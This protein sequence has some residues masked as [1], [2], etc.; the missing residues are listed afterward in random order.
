MSR[1]LILSL[2]LVLVGSAM[3]AI[4]AEP[5]A[6]Q[7]AVI[8]AL[9]GSEWR[10]SNLPGRNLAQV[11]VQR[12][13]TI[14]FA[15]G[16]MSGRG[17]CNNLT[18][19]YTLGAPGELRMGRV[20]GATLP[21]REVESLERHFI[22]QL[23]DVTGYRIDGDRLVLVTRRGREVSF[24]RLSAVPRDPGGSSATEPG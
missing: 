13:P 22:R 20:G 8:D 11:P 10:L 5:E 23:E 24:E 7:P 3:P 21:C 6:G 17:L 14:A 18:A 15:D 19:A 9:D 16:R 1:S 12:R 4:A 2:L